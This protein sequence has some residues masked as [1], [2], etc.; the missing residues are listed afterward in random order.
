MSVRAQELYDKGHFPFF[1]WKNKGIKNVTH[2]QPGQVFQPLLLKNVCELKIEQI[3]F[4]RAGVLWEVTL[5]VLK[6]TQKTFKTA[7]SGG[8]S[9]K[10]WETTSENMGQ[11]PGSANTCSFN[12]I[13]LSF[14]P[15]CT[16]YKSCIILV[17]SHSSPE[18]TVNVC[19]SP[20][21]LLW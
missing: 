12:N 8:A 10:N 1:W 7:E 15:N 19:Y 3:M 13:C 21:A 6:G 17:K 11:K 20:H 9:W 5:F 14:Y 18:C 4:I 2:S 16:Q